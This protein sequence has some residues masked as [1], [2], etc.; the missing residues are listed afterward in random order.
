MSGIIPFPNGSDEEVVDEVAEGLRPEWL[1]NSL[2]QELVDTL[3]EHIE[4]CWNQEPKERPTASK[5]LQTLLALGNGGN[6][7]SV[8]SVENAEDEVTETE[9]EQV[10]D[11]PDG[12]FVLAVVAWSLTLVGL[13]FPSP[14][15]D[16]MVHAGVVYSG[17]FSARRLRNAC[18][19]PPHPQKH[20]LGTTTTETAG[21]PESLVE[22]PTPGIETIDQREEATVRDDYVPRVVEE[23][24]QG[25]VESTDGIER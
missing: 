22:K 25:P 18:P 20:V 5:V 6:R 13:Q 15:R 3:R 11:T 8:V 10:E 21:T 12:M 1:S 2:S 24:L 9:W 23:E 7:E 17:V 16:L 14:T 19:A 4:A